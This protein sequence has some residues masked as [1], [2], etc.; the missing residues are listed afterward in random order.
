MRKIDSDAAPVRV[1]L[2]EWNACTR[3]LARLEAQIADEMGQNAAYIDALARDAGLLFKM[4]LIG[5]A[6]QRSCKGSG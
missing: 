1:P 3:Q 6:A 4:Q 5:A 2:R